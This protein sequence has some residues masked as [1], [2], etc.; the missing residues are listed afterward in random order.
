[1]KCKSVQFVFDNGNV[2]TFARGSNEVYNGNIEYYRGK[3]YTYTVT[4][5][6]KNGTYT[7]CTFS[8]PSQDMAKTLLLN[9]LK[10]KV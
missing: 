3:R 2:V 7:I 8:S 5:E 4:I 1:M 6:N 9:S 10:E